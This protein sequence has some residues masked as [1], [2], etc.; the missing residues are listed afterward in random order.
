MLNIDWPYSNDDCQTVARQNKSTLKFASIVSLFSIQKY[1]FQHFR[2]FPQNMQES[3]N[4]SIHSASS[5][6]EINSR[7]DGLADDI[8]TPK[9]YRYTLKDA[10]RSFD[11]LSRKDKPIAIA[12]LGR[13]LLHIMTSASISGVV[14]Q[15]D[16]EN[17]GIQMIH[18]SFTDKDDAKNQYILKFE[19]LRGWVVLVGPEKLFSAIGKIDLLGS[20]MYADLETFP[21]IV[22]GVIGL[23]R[24]HFYGTLDDFFLASA[25]II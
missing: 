18:E 20:F 5:F 7:K 4:Y 25:M 11:R 21:Y 16:Q 8:I 10:Q 14:M 13:R 12:F 3:F 17:G 2:T 15:I 23:A 1:E 19:A 24:R 9:C 22:D 6:I